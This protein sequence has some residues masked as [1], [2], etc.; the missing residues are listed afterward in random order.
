MSAKKQ[1]TIVFVCTGNTCRSPMAEILLREHLKKRG[2]KGFSVCS[3]GIAVKDGDKINPL[4][5]QALE[6]NGITAEDFSSTALDDK[7]L[8]DAFAIVCMTEK[9]REILMDM[10]WNA[11]RKTGAEDIENNVRSFAEITG[12]EI[13]DPYGKD[14]ECYRYV[15]GLIEAGMSA[16]VEKLELAKYAQVPKPRK[17]RASTTAKKQTATNV[18]PKKR[19]RPKKSETATKTSTTKK[20]NK[21]TKGD[22]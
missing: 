10:R 2:L 19:G 6:E 3:A 1:K 13:L 17:P 21:K 12:Y 16:L 14:I 15:F 11:L 8:R 20:Q 7:I 9:Q 18:A 5:K 22:N 4:S